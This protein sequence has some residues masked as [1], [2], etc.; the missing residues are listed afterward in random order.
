MS[1][2]IYNLFSPI[3]DENSIDH[4]LAEMIKELEGKLGEEFLEISA[5]E[6]KNYASPLIFVK[7]GGV[8]GRFKEIYQRFQEPYTILASDTNNSLAASLEILTFLK[9]QGLKAE[10]IHGDVSYL[11]SRINIIQKATAAKQRLNGINVGAIGKPSD[12]L[13]ASDVDYQKVENT[14][15]IKVIELEITELLAEIKKVTASPHLL[16]DLKNGVQ[17]GKIES[18]YQE[19]PEEKSLDGALNIYLALKNICVKYHL[20]GLTIRCFDLLNTVY[21]TGCI[22]LA[23]LNDEGII[24]ACEGDLPALLSMLILNTLTGEPVFM[25]NPSSIDTK[26]NQIILAH[27]TLP[28]SMADLFTLNTHFESNIGVGIH[29]EIRSGEATIFRL[30]ADLKRYFVSGITILENQYKD[31]LCRTQ[32]KVKMHESVQHLL[33][34]PMGNHHLICKGDYT[35]LVNYF[36][37]LKGLHNCLKYP[38]DNN[39]SN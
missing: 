20:Q 38:F 33:L 18:L 19:A 29:G 24:S 35:S 32:I 7:S 4:S 22:A 13:I 30:N 3:H 14:F 28:L 23:L 37:D 12:W 31:N 8:E 27:C 9:Q 16:A 25:A 1:I 36:M 2:P 21:N 34:N 6:I 11:A 17:K 10:I 26:S 5:D 39:I 15:G